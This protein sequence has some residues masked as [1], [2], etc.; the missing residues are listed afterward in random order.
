MCACP[1]CDPAFLLCLWE[2]LAGVTWQGVVPKFRIW[3]HMGILDWALWGAT[4][5]L[6]CALGVALCFTLTIAAI[7]GV[8]RL[9]RALSG[10]K[11]ETVLGVFHPY[12]SVPC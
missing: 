2:S 11:G 7:A 3:L 4:A 1:H 6:Y 5:C 9:R 12:W 8:L 10:E